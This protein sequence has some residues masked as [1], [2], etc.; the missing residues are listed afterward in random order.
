MMPDTF[1]C[2]FIEG[3]AVLPGGYPDRSVKVLLAGDERFPL[4][5]YFSRRHCWYR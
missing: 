5:Q 2:I 1:R 4:E 3:S